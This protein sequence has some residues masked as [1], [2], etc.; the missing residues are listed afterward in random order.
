[1]YDYGETIYMCI[2]TLE[3][4]DNIVLKPSVRSSSYEVIVTR[5]SETS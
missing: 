2:P 3:V 4:R 1:M 5:Y